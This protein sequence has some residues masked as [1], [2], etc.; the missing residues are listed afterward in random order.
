MRKSSLTLINAAA[1]APDFKPPPGFPRPAAAL[2]RDICNHL[3]AGGRFHHTDTALVAQYVRCLWEADRARILVED[4]GM[5]IDGS[6]GPKAH[7]L[8]AVVNQ[9]RATATKIASGLGLGPMHRARIAAP[10]DGGAQDGQGW[11]ASGA[12]R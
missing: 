12:Q 9:C 8:I 11:H 1:P 5:V 6:Q 4:Q 10:V 7:P 3:H 2:Y